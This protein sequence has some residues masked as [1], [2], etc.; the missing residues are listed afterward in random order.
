MS[1]KK[2]AKRQ[3]S[4]PPPATTAATKKKGTTASNMSTTSD[5]L[6]S[7]GYLISC[8]I[9][10]KQYIQSLNDLKPVDKKFIL[11]DL[12]STHVLVTLASQGEIDRKLEEWF[13]E[14]VFSPIDKVG[15]DLDL[16]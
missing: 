7:A 11:Q 6:P 13:N 14:N 10:T 5:D 1:S 4:N 2:K 16:S 9:P 8:D 3:Q 12:D 15:E